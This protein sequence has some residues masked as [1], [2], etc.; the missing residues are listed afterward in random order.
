[1][2]LRR[3]Q[4]GQPSSLAERSRRPHHC[5]YQTPPSVEGV[6]GRLLP[7]DRLRRRAAQTRVRAPLQHRRHPT[8][9]ARP[10]LGAAASQEARPQEATAPP[11]ENLATVRPTGCRPQVSAR[12]SPVLAAD[13]AT[14]PAEIIRRDACHLDSAIACWRTLDPSASLRAGSRPPPQPILPPLRTPSEGSRST[15][16]SLNSA[17]A[18]T[19]RTTRCV[20]IR[21]GCRSESRSSA[22]RRGRWSPDD[23][24]VLV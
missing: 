19:Y 17:T 18:A 5:P 9:R 6:V 15:C 21:C 3:F 16:L 20:A 12:H 4:P 7:P 22:T 13:D 10:R 23:G 1:V 2:K 11:E 8:D 24:R 14:A